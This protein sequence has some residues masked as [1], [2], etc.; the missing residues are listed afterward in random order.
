[1]HSEALPG[2]NFMRNKA[3]QNDK[4]EQ[5]FVSIRLLLFHAKS[6]CQCQEKPG[7]EPLAVL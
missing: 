6:F 1:M 7:N 3:E 5:E 2:S 4:Q